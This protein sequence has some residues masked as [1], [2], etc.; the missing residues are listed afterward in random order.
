MAPTYAI[1][2][3]AYFE[4]NLYESSVKIQQYKNK[5]YEIMET[6]T[7]LYLEMPIND[8]HNLP[9]NTLK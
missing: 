3:L 9:E 8:L 4:E 6:M 7:V 1:L 5:I 2:N